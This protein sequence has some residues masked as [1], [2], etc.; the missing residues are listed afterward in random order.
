MKPSVLEL[1]GN[2]AFVLL[3]H[4]NTKEIAAKAAACRISSLGGQRCNSSKRFIILEKH[5]DAFVTYMGEYMK[6]MPR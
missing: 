5:Y 4:T 1:G 6:Q 3:D 2:D